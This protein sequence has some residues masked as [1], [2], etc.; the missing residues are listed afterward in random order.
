MLKYS[1]C[2][3][4]FQF[5]VDQVREVGE[6]QTQLELRVEPF[7][8]V[9]GPILLLLRVIQFLPVRNTRVLQ[10][11]TNRLPQPPDGPVAQHHLLPRRHPRHPRKGLAASPVGQKA[12]GRGRADAFSRAFSSWHAHRVARTQRIG[13]DR[14]R[15]GPWCRWLTGTFAFSYWN[16]IHKHRM[17]WD[18]IGWVSRGCGCI[19]VASRHGGRVCAV[20]REGRGVNLVVQ[21]LAELLTLGMRQ[22]GGLRHDPLT[23]LLGVGIGNGVSVAAR[24]ADVDVVVGVVPVEA[25]RRILVVGPCA[26]HDE[27]VHEPAR[28]QLPL[29]DEKVLF[30]VHLGALCAA[31]PAHVQTSHGNALRGRG[32]AQAH[33][34]RPELRPEEEVARRVADHVQLGVA[35]P[36]TRQVV[37][38]I[39]E[40]HPKIPV[41]VR[42]GN[43]R[44]P[45]KSRSA[46]YI[47]TLSFPELTE[48]L[49]KQSH[50]RRQPQS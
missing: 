46:M 50:R 16:V 45:A 40:I 33:A 8:F 25:H 11:Q 14:L 23:H 3:R 27:L 19:A 17:G 31:A 34:H 5:A 13:S 30:A 35:R 22:Q 43:G 21:N 32:S 48:C 28:R 6:V 37:E 7:R 1:D 15:G 12:K 42:N 26:V 9:E 38:S 47:D 18:R 49:L 44:C 24:A 36:E 10:K 29:E 20:G 39:R 41:H 4:Q 2:L